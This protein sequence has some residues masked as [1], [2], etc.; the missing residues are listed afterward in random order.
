MSAYEIA[1]DLIGWWTRLGMGMTGACHPGVFVV[2]DRVPETELDEKG[3]MRYR[4]D[5]KKRTIFRP[6]TNEE[7][8]AMWKE[9]FAHAKDAD[10]QYGEYLIV[11][12]DF[13]HGLPTDDSRRVPGIS[14]Q[15]RMACDFYGVKR[16][17]TLEVTSST[18]KNCPMCTEAVAGVAILCPKCGWCLDPQTY[19][20]LIKE[21][22]ALLKDVEPPTPHIALQNEQPTQ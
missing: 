5:A 16:K 7:R 20:R 8:T 10:A 17:W 9:D 14:P 21:Q 12:G 13:I 11:K 3:N 4:L 1:D 19:R 15:M 6:A 18:T 2:R 22:R